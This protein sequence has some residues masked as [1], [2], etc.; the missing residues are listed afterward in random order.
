MSSN[1]LVSQNTYEHSQRIKIKKEM[2]KLIQKWNALNRKLTYVK[3][4]NTNM[5]E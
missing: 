3:E 1:L 4:E 2:L 5:M